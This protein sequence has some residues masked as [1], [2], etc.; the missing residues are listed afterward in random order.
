MIYKMATKNIIPF[1][2]FVTKNKYIYLK[3]LGGYNFNGSL[4]MKAKDW[5]WNKN[6]R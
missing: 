2:D 1:K 3:F 4:N 5:T 6:I